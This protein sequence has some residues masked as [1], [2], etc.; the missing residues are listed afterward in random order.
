MLSKVFVKQ[1]DEVK[2]NQPLFM[3]EAMKMETNIAAS[4]DGIVGDII[5]S[6]GTLV[7]TD[8]LVLEFR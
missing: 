7:N 8:D 3:V 5:L 1:G 6:P 2:K 4:A